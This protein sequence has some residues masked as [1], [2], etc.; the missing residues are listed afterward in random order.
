[1]GF[2]RKWV[3]KK[4]LKEELENLNKNYNRLKNLYDEDNSYKE[5]YK[6]CLVKLENANTNYDNL[7]EKYRKECT[8]KGGLVKHNNELERKLNENATL[9][10]TKEKVIHNLNVSVKDFK[11]EINVKDNQIISLN[12]MIK[13]LKSEKDDSDNQIRNLNERIK[14]LESDRYLKVETKTINRKRKTQVMSM[15]KSG[16]RTGRI[17]KE[18]KEK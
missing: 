13:S 14:D 7:N 3:S 18:L 5:K 17:M 16:A 4:E 8:A 11:N 12:D 9:L 6:D 2:L 1:M 15:A 10:E